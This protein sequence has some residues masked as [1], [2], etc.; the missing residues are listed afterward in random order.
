MFNKKSN[1]APISIKE[2]ILW[3]SVGCLF[4]QACLWSTTVL[5]V[6]ISGY[7][8]SGALAYATALG[9]MY[10]AL[11]IY[12]MRVYQ[13]SDIDNEYTQS[14]YIAFRLVT[15][16]GAA[17]IMVAYLFATTSSSLL[18]I[19]TL[20]MLVFKADEA[21]CSA[22]Y[23]I[24]Q[25]GSRMD[26]IGKS[27]IARGILIVV[28]FVGMLALT[29]NLGLTIL[30]MSVLCISITFLYDAKKASLFSN[31]IPHVEFKQIKRLL[32]KCFPAALTLLLFGSIVSVARQIYEH[33]F[34]EEMLGIYAA[35]A[36][37]TVIIQVLATYLYS[38]LIVPIAELW[39]SHEYKKLFLYIAKVVI[40]L[41]GITLVAILAAVLWGND[42]MVFIYGES[43]SPYTG[44]LPT[45][46]ISVASAALMA[47]YID[48][49]IAFRK[50]GSALLSS[51]IAFVFML[52]FSTYFTNIY[53]MDGVNIVITISFILGIAAGIPLLFKQ[54]RDASN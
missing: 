51:S 24:V 44:I 26:Y 3:N 31:I 53:G 46:I 21:M 8:D 23:A 20:C 52:T 11:A 35:I 5:V 45:T 14:N 50:L 38:P 17:V 33:N 13:I 25:R 37:P 29:K 30:T 42:V 7:E 48:L 28:S 15:I 16:F 2:N 49:M 39:H 41:I 10:F 54:Q 27:Q 40:A 36:T 18:L 47:L 19:V 22:Y 12:N 4:Y 1:K 34:G 6:I 32:K 9:N 43:I